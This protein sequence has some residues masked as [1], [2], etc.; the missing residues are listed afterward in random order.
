[1][2]LSRLQF[3]RLR[4]RSATHVGVCFHISRVITFHRV[5]SP[6]RATCAFLGR[7]QHLSY[8]IQRDGE[9]FPPHKY[10]AYA[11]YR[12]IHPFHLQDLIL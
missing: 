4:T 2:L 8:K 3:Y 12:T 1:M 7:H 9:Q 5:V 11:S 6:V 10:P